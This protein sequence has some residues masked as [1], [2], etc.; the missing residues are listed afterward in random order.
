MDS[1]DFH[2]TII[3]FICRFSYLVLELEKK[4]WH[5]KVATQV[6]FGWI[7]IKKYIRLKGKI[8]GK[9]CYF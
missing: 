8:W 5:A 7:G 2:Q 4:N 1:L 3:K 9:N 6:K